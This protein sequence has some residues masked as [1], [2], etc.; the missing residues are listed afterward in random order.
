MNA[1]HQA[2]KQ[3]QKGEDQ[4]RRPVRNQSKQH[5]KGNRDSLSALKVIKTG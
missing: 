5:A 4:H 3:E 1:E 2:E